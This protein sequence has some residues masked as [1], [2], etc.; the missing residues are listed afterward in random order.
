MNADAIRKIEQLVLN[1]RPIIEAPDYHLT[2]RYY[3]RDSN[4][5]L[6][7]NYAARNM[8][9]ARLASTRDLAQ[10]ARHRLQHQHDQMPYAAY[11]SSD[12][13]RL[14]YAHPDL[15]DNGTSHDAVPL[16]AHPVFTELS[17]LAD[18]REFTQKELITWLRATMNGHVPETLIQHFRSLT[19]STEGEHANTVAVSGR[20]SVSRKIAQ[21]V[22]AEAGHDVMEEFVVS[23]PVY[24]LLELRTV[25]DAYQNVTILVDVST[26]DAGR[27]IFTLTSVLDTVRAAIET[28]QTILRNALVEELE[29]AEVNV[30]LFLQP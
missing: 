15:P 25:T 27:V 28:T 29:T 2:G 23:T 22:A 7:G 17:D 30:P 16:R 5:D 10:H 6:I 24:D 14:V 4:G 13:I 12:A 26:D 20:E 19:F 18:G 21:R 11:I 8:I 1:G 9:G 3:T